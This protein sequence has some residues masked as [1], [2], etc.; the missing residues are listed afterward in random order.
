MH[1]LVLEGGGAKGSY[2]I[3][4]YKALKELNVEI[5]GIAGTSIG[6]LNG[7]MIVQDDYERCYDLWCDI[8]YS[9]VA[10]VDDEDIDKIM[11]LKLVREDLSF[12]KDKIKVLI[13]G[14]GLDITPL[15]GLLDIYIDEEKIRK[16][17][18]DFGM[19][20]INL[21]QRKPLYAFVEDIPAGELKN[22][23]MASAY[24]PIF[25][26]EKIN[27]ERFLD[28]GFYDNLPFKMLLE[29]GYKDLILV[30][31]HAM[32][33]TRKIDLPSDVNALLISPSDNI[34]KSYEYDGNKAKKNIELGY[35]D[36]LKAIKGLKGNKYYIHPQGDKDY[37]FE[38]LLNIKEEE[39][40]EIEKI[41]KLPEIPY[42]RSLFEHIIPKICSMLSIGKDC[43]YEELF[44]YLLE[45]KAECLNIEKF[46]VYDFRDLL[47]LVEDR[48]INI[49]KDELGP[50]DKLIE[51]VDIIP[52]LN[53]ENTL[54][55][56]AD[57]LFRRR[58]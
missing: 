52:A 10:D 8:T 27:G 38:F 44:I 20:A 33:Y 49:N 43:S 57:I 42:R 23:L 41:L 15:K 35:Y 26:S 12:L 17:K 50:L 36:G 46:K 24:L 51:K 40:R 28:G 22:H 55:E 6:A 45:K 34:G 2:H 39:V 16:S 1:G 14:R 58:D 9:M 7:A 3:G 56:I 18:M 13:T 54:L 19:V 5:G 29:K 47:S 21:S 25:K 37:Y 11:Q 48:A 30:R 4:V 31:T 32:G 53:K